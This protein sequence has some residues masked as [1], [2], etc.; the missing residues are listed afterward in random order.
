MG[1]FIQMKL[2]K[3][4]QMKYDI[5]DA[6]ASKDKEE[7]RKASYVAYDDVIEFPQPV[8]FTIKRL[9]EIIGEVEKAKLTGD[10]IMVGLMIEIPIPEEL[11][12]KVGK[13]RQKY[14]TKSVIKKYNKLK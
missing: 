1:E 13:K 12:K 10:G 5:L 9:K 14:K 7:L 2:K 3:R 11:Q 4:L 8:A 6:L